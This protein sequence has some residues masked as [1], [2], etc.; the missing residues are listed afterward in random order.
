MD[1]YPGIKAAQ[2]RLSPN[3]CFSIGTF[4]GVHL[5]HQRLIARLDE[6]AADGPAVVLTFRRHPLSVVKPELAPK[7]LTSVERRLELLALAGAD[8]VILSEFEESFARLTAA[9][10]LDRLVDELGMSGLVR[11]YDHRFGS[12]HAGP[13]RLSQLLDERKLRDY[14]LDPVRECG[15][16]AK[17]QTVRQLLNEGDV[18]RAACLLG[19]PHRLLGRIQR[20]I[21]LARKLGVPTANIPDYYEMPPKPGV[22]VVSGRIIGRTLRGVANIGWRHEPGD[23][24]ERPLLEVHLFGLEREAYGAAVAVDFLDRLRD[25]MSFSSLDDLKTQI[26]RDVERARAWWNAYPNGLAST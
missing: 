11:G 13:E 16:I 17:S 20:G 24:T 12:D 8:A 5:G 23:S 26:H 3:G 22:Y 9:Q 18:R 6:V 1:V 19:K 14:V 4:D 10:L 2:G 7:P 25:E 21:G 15:L